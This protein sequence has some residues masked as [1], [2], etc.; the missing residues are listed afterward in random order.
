[1]DDA[2]L[3]E[4][5][6]EY[7]KEKVMPTRIKNKMKWRAENWW[8]HGYPARNAQCSARHYVL[9]RDLQSRRNIGFFALAAEQ[10]S[11]AFYA[12]DSVRQR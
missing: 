11:L 2:A 4:A 9:Y 1:M 10:D 7:V 3:Y 5:P 6:F 8:L 12:V